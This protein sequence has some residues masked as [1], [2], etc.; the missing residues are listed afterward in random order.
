[1]AFP[2]LQVPAGQNVVIDSAAHTVYAD[3]EPG[4]SR[5]HFLDFA[6]ATWFDLVPGQ[7]V[8][9]VVSNTF[10]APSQTVVTWRD[11]YIS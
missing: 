7:N 10:S 2:S 8:L 1:L 11:A 6:T 5:Y 3:G 4:S 9:R